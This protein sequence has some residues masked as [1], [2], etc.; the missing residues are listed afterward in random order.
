MNKYNVVV[1]DPPWFFFDAL[2][3]S[4]VKRGA[5]SQYQTLSFTDIKNLPVKHI[6]SDDAVLAL[7]VPGSLLQEGLDT[8]KAWGFEQKQVH[9]WVKTK[10][11]PLG[12][13]VK[14][15]KVPTKKEYKAT[16]YKFDLIKNVILGT[17]KILNWYDLNNVLAFGMGRLFRQTHELCLI[18][19]RGSPYKNLKNKSQRS[20]HFA[21]VTKHSAKPENLQDMLDIMFP[22]SNKIELF[23]RRERPGWKCLGNQ[24]PSSKDKDIRDSL[25]KLISKKVFIEHYKNV[26]TEKYIKDGLVSW[27]KN[28]KKYGNTDLSPVDCKYLLDNLK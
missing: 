12:D 8:M 17:K 23:A 5:E 4:N 14:Y 20:V 2:K 1:A 22:E 19:T 25:K 6:V 21:P 13:L 15:L 3:M 26:K 27:L 11:D 24:C 16:A 7:W 28:E 10:K 9:V 18:G